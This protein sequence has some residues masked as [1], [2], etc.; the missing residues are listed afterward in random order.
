VPIASQT[1]I[2]KKTGFTTTKGLSIISH[3]VITVLYLY[4]KTVDV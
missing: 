1:K 3:T 4:I 2:I